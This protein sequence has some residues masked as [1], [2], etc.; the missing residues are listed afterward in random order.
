MFCWMVSG[1]CF[2]AKIIVLNSARI[3][4]LCFDYIKIVGVLNG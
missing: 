3:V 4:V 1:G 2:E